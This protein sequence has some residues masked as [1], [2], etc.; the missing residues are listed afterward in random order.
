MPEEFLQVVAAFDVQEV[1]ELKGNEG[2]AFDVTLGGGAGPEGRNFMT[3]G[4]HEDG[5]GTGGEGHAGGNVDAAH[6]DIAADAGFTDLEGTED[7]VFVK[8]QRVVLP[9]V[10]ALGGPG[11]ET[12]QVAAGP[13]EEILQRG[14]Q[15]RGYQEVAP[16][17]QVNVCG[18]S[19]VGV[20]RD[21]GVDFMVFGKVHRC[22]SSL[23][24]NGRIFI[25]RKYVLRRL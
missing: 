1:L 3:A 13:G 8:G 16:V 11:A 19:F 5:G 7:K 12:G 23:F 15:G 18:V 6:T 20:F 9:L 4:G 24:L 17:A 25:L 22:S 21:K 2:A 10:G 14:A